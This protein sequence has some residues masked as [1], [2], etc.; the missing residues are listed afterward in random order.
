LIVEKLGATSVNRQS[1][2]LIRG[3]QVA[4]EAEAY[5]ITQRGTE[6]CRYSPHAILEARLNIGGILQAAERCRRAAIVDVIP[7]INHVV[8][9]EAVIYT[10]ETGI[11]GCRAGDTASPQTVHRNAVVHCAFRVGR[12]RKR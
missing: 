6:Q 4:V 3:I 12:G 1:G 9:V 11:L 5:F 2:R 10:N 8:A 7:R